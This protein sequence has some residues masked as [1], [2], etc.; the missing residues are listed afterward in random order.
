MSYFP[1][2]LALLEGF[3]NL[4]REKGDTDRYLDC[5]RRLAETS[6]RLETTDNP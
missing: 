4:L 3:K 2:D 1:E 5:S 6:V